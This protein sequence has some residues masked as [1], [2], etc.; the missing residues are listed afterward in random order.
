M[1]RL[2]EDLNKKCFSEYINFLVSRLILPVTTII[3]RYIY[4]LT[5]LNYLFN[6]I[7]LFNVI[8]KYKSL[9]RIIQKK[10]NIRIVIS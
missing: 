7:L 4:Q 1:G 5:N 10:I 6:P 2:Q 8:K 3:R 9:F